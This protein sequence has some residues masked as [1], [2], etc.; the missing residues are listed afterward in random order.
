MPVRHWCRLKQIVITFV[1]SYRF[2][3]FSVTFFLYNFSIVLNTWPAVASNKITM[4]QYK[5]VSLFT[6]TIKLSNNCSSTRPFHWTIV[7]VPVQKIRHLL[8]NSTV[9]GDNKS[10]FQHV[11]SLL[12]NGNMG[13]FTAGD[14][15][16]HFISCCVTSI[17]FCYGFFQ[18]FCQS[19]GQGTKKHAQTS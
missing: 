16:F 17:F 6:H 10:P 12:S 11:G 19:P 8:S 15:L 9:I 13:N 3:S 5:Y 4:H 2:K 18:L 1:F 7:L 14:I